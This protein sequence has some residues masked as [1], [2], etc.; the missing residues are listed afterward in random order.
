MIKRLFILIAILA[1]AYAG[2]LYYQ[3]TKSSGLSAVMNL[4]PINSSK[5]R[6]ASSLEF[7]N[8]SK[9]L[10]TATNGV[11]GV[12]NTATDGEAEPIINQTLENLQNEVK[13]LPKKQYEKVKYEFCKDVVQE[14]ESNSSK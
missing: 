4:S 13:D 10:G 1:L 14:Y 5:I 11:L 8:L 9:V 7:S 6:S 12:L 2:F 3:S